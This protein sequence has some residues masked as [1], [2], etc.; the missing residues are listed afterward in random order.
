MYLLRVRSLGYSSY[1]PERVDAYISQKQSCRKGRITLEPWQLPR[2]RQV[3]VSGFAELAHRS[4]LPNKSA[5]SSEMSGVAD[6]RNLD[7]KTPTVCDRG[8][9]RRHRRSPGHGPRAFQSI[10][11]AGSLLSRDPDGATMC[12]RWSPTVPAPTG[13]PCSGI[14]PW[15][16]TS[17]IGSTPSDGSRKD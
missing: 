6:R 12:V 10:L 2:T 17:S 1:R 8:R 7:Q 14:F 13:H 4:P 16:V 5:A 11:R 9:Q 3:M 15:L